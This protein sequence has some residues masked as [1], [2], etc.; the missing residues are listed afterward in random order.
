M[1]KSSLL[2]RA[3]YTQGETALKLPGAGQFSLTE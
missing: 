1:S 2:I 3:R